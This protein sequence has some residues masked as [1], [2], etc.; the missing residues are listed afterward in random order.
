[1][2]ELVKENE[3]LQELAERYY[4]EVAELQETSNQH[5][6]E[7]DTLLKF[8]EKLLTII[9]KEL[10]GQKLK[11]SDILSLQPIS[12]K[13]ETES[14]MFQ[15]QFTNV[16]NKLLMKKSLNLKPD[17]RERA[18]RPEP[19]AI[20]E[21]EEQFSIDVEGNE[22]E[23]EGDHEIRSLIKEFRK[24]AKVTLGEFSLPE[25]ERK[26]KDETEA[27]SKAKADSS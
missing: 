8:N 12:E 27:L 13:T 24:K 22:K 1:M 4:K 15:S 9:E 2:E 14:E 17:P 16:G 3:Y 19:L 5:E 26:Y 25:I 10:N 21:R 7:I 20:V 6:A 11:N 23:E 18:P